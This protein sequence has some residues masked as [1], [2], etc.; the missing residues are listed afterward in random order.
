VTLPSRALPI[1]MPFWKPGFTFWSDLRV[2]NKDRVVGVDENAARA[3]K[4][5]P[6]FQKSP[7]LV[8]MSVLSCD[9]AVS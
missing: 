4:L 8:E 6:L 2:G 1:R 3:G 9:P 7:V 5:F